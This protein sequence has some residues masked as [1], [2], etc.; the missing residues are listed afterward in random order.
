VGT[1]P[2][3]SA[4][5]VTK[6]DEDRVRGVAHKLAREVGLLHAVDD[7]IGYGYVGLVEAQ[8]SYDPSRG[9]PFGAFAYHRIR[10]AMIDGA[11]R[12]GGLSR[13]TC[14]RLAAANRVLEDVAY[15]DAH[16]GDAPDVEEIGLDVYGALG[17]LVGAFV[18]VE[19]AEDEKTPETLVDDEMH[20][21]RVRRAVDALPDRPRTVLVGL[22]F[23][24][25]KLEDLARQL[26]TSIAT[27][28]RAHAQGLGLLRDALGSASG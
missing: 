4:A 24:D 21:L 12:I 26:E 16:A 2:A 25:R 10:W 11:P 9:V 8:Q 14:A 28:W 17:K 1:R 22:Y 5:A 20:K 23:E 18:L 19:H 3:A 7:L 27:A 6:E 15:T 13:R